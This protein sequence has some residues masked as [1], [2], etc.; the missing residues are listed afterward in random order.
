MA[1]QR[2][3]RIVGQALVLSVIVLV[4][5]AVGGLALW[6]G[7]GGRL[8]SVQ[9]GSMVP[10]IWP[11]DAVLVRQAPLSQ[12][13]SGDIISYVSPLHPG[14]I[15]THRVERVDAASGTVVTKGDKAALA[16][17]AVPIASILGRV[18]YLVPKL[19]YGLDLLHHPLGLIIGVYLPA[20]WIVAAEAHRLARHYAGQY[21][22]LYGYRC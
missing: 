20:L 13:N 5:L 8:L 14:L 9:T 2:T 17:P 4:V 19:G 10:A 12:I 3:S 18:D 7:Q 6:H 1:L 16:D 21:Y 22:R 15:I 11:G